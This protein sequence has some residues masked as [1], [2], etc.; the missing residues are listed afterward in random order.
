MA[1]NLVRRI[2]RS[3]LVRNSVF[4]SVVYSQQTII[5]DGHDV[6]TIKR[7]GK[8]GI[9]ENLP[10]L[11]LKR[12][13]GPPGDVTIVSYQITDPPTAAEIVY[14]RVQ[15]MPITFT[16]TVD[17]VSVGGEINGIE[18]YFVDS[19]GDEIT[20]T[21][22]DAGGDAPTDNDKEDITGGSVLT[23]DDGS[24][25]VTAPPIA[26]ILYTRTD[27]TEITLTMKVS[28]GDTNSGQV[29]AVVVYFSDGDSKESKRESGTLE[30]TI[31]I[32]V[33]ADE[34]P[35]ENVK[36][37]LKMDADCLDY[38]HLCAEILDGI[39]Q[40]NAQCIDLG[41]DTGDAGDS[42]CSI[43]SIESA[44]LKITSPKPSDITYTTHEDTKI[45]FDLKAT[46]VDADAEV[47]GVNVYF[48]NNKNDDTRVES[49]AVVAGGDAPTPENPV[50][51]DKDSSTDIKGCE[52]T[53]KLDE[54]ACASY[55]HLCSSL[56]AVGGVEG[57]EC[58]EFGSEDTEA[59][60]KD[61]GKS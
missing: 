46:T 54:G 27:V 50:K 7:Y 25:E 29:D 42:D 52:A 56:S 14:N 57:E 6:E 36:V 18:V 22:Q 16:V 47:T 12:I 15:D 4:F 2:G 24:L 20:G 31:P 41:T 44:S 45:T 28:P 8:W 49:D 1:F 48:T 32:P 43:A 26:D 19:S 3:Y 39:I 34:T 35:L 51:I 61:C 5:G 17:A 53:L 30:G 13:G 58:I 10:T 38:E 9:L 37:T 33:N 23:I 55:T 11:K 59:G 60:E 21:N 40:W